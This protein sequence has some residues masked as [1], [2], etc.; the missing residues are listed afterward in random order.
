[1]GLFERY[2][3]LWLGICICICICIVVAVFLR[4]LVPS[5]FL[6][7]AW[8]EWAQVNLVVALLIWEMIH[9]MMVQI[10]FSSIKNVGKKPK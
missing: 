9:P 1:M 7:V 4:S 6:Q 5:A 3:S 10:D 8:L 2:L